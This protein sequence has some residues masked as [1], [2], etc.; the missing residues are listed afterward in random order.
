MNNNKSSNN[1]Q[2]GGQ[3]VIEGV[4][5]RGRKHYAVACRKSNNEIVVKQENV[6]SFMKGF[7]WL[8]KPFLRGTL[9]LIDAMVLGMK[10][11]IFSANLQLKEIDEEERK[12]KQEQSETIAPEKTEEAKSETINDIRVMGSVV[13]GLAF[14]ILLFVV[15]PN[16]LAHLVNK[17]VANPF[18]M[19]IIEGFVKIAIFFLYIYLISKMKDIQ[20]IFMYHGAE[21]KVINTYESGLPLTLENISKYG[22]IHTRCGTS[23]IMIVLVISIFV[24]FFV[25]WS[26]IWYWRILAR[27]AL[28]PVIAGIAYEIIKFAGRHQGSKLLRV[29]LAPGLWMQKITTREPTDDQVEVALTA[30][31]SVFQVEQKTT[32]Q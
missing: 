2:Y 26:D 15:G 17:Q 24:H 3:A 1:T 14:G 13:L 23:F 7:Q 9:A 25:G 19:N 27:L 28:L 30:L 12:K 32:I 8:N 10:T 5:M 29:L 21:H 4:M 6:E 18:L 22:T 16:I 11:L 20:R 31:N